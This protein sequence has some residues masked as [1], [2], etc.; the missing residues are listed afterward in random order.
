MK[1]LFLS[2]VALMIA[3]LSY[4][5]NTMVATLTHG[6][7]ITMYYGSNAL[8]EAH[9]AAV[10]GDVISLSDGS[11]QAVDIT[12]A[13]TLRGIGVD[14]ENPTYIAGDFIFNIPA[15][16][17]GRFSMEGIRCTGI[18]QMDGMLDNA[19]FFKCIFNDFLALS[20][21]NPSVY[22][23]MFANCK[24]T[25]QF[26]LHGIGTMQFVNSYIRGF[27]NITPYWNSN[28]GAI[29]NNCILDTYGSAHD[30]FFYPNKIKYSHLFNC[31]LISE[32]EVPLS[33]VGAQPTYLPTSSI[34]YN[35]VAINQDHIFGVNPANSDC[36]T[37]TFEE[38]FKDFT[39]VYSDEQTF[40]LTEAGKAQFLGTDGTQV[41]M[42]GGM[43]PYNSIPSYPRITKMNV[44]NKSTD[45]SKLNV[46][47]EVSAG[48]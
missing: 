34:A 39:G 28:A 15:D 6:D 32:S 29:F 48:E 30:S 7:D 5:Q 19:C 17:T 44:A 2:M 33:D 23:V 14:E 31:I 13:I 35:C 21:K 36:K 41:G 12:K 27:S 22:N 20:G 26:D 16:D 1:K 3:T 9:E 11:F 42:Y 25:Y 37:S 46:E 4:A 24:I 43:L 38:M 47:I 10:S 8:I 40:E 18:I 45:D